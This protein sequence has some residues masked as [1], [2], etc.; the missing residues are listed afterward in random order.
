M[1]IR[2][3]YIGIGGFI[4]SNLRYLISHTLSKAI[5]FP[6]GTLVVN[7]IGSFLLG[8]LMMVS[9]EIIPTDSKI[10][11][12][13]GTGMLGAFTTFST[14]SWETLSMLSDGKYTLALGNIGL[15]ITFG[16][17][18]VWIGFMVGK[19]LIM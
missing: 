16:L 2:I 4:G 18:S 19:A 6:L 5:T 14:L 9:N 11:L 3:I 7:C 13:L 15:N 12:L 10:K 8:L 1:L 17:I